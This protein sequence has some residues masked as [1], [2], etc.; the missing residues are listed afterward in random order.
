MQDQGDEFVG[1]IG[2]VDDTETVFAD[3]PDR[4]VMRAFDFHA[5]PPLEGA[6]G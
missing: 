4:A 2:L 5:Y 6:N 3:G 1:Q